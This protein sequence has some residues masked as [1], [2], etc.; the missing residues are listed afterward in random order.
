M[1][2]ESACGADGGGQ[3]RRRRTALWKT[4]VGMLGEVAL[5]EDIS[6]AEEGRTASC[7]Q[8]LQIVVFMG[9]LFC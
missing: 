1:D 8:E 9:A 5:G 2:G 6:T 7:H 4:A 3:G